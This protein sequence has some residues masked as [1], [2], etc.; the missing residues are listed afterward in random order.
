MAK[1]AKA[2][3]MTSP[4]MGLVIKK[5]PLLRVNKGCILVKI[6]CCTICG[7][8]VH[9]WIGRRTAPTPIILGHEIVGTIAELEEGFTHDSGD[10]K[11]NVGDRITWTIMDKCGAA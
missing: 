7:S 2:A 6:T 9:S 5:Y 1:T 4:R 3:V 8:D 11:L 10:R